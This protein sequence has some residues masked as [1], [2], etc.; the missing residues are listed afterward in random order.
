MPAVFYCANLVAFCES[1]K[2]LI[3]YPQGG[4]ILAMPMASRH[5]RLILGGNLN[6]IE[7]RHSVKRGGFWLFVIF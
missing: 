7:W 1:T 6:Y 5:E 2:I 3:K 4:G